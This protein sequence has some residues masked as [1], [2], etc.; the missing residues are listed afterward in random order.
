M[1][2]H[3]EVEKLRSNIDA[4]ADAAAAEAVACGVPLSPAADDA[5]K[6]AW[7]RHVVDELDRRFPEETIRA[8]RAGCHCDEAGRLGEMKEWLGRVYRESEGM[9]DFV[10]RMNRLG[11]GWRMEDGAIYTTFHSCECYMLREVDR[12]PSNAWCHCTAGYTKNLF[13]HVFG[14]EV[15][16][17]LV[18]SVKRGAERCVVR[19]TPK[20]EAPPQ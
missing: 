11:A 4:Y 14:R 13:E 10:D 16:S 17:E 18:Q 8:I 19:V 1:A 3:P 20:G 2:S 9:E 7:V 6:A 15:E 12:L 5:E